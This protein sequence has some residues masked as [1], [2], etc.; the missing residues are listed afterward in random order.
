MPMFERPLQMPRRR[1]LQKAGMA[2][3]P[4]KHTCTPVTVEY[5]YEKWNDYRLRVPIGKRPAKVEFELV[6]QDIDRFCHY[7]TFWK[8]KNSLVI[9]EDQDESWGFALGAAV[10]KIGQR[11]FIGDRIRIS[12][13]VPSLR[14]EATV[15]DYI[16]TRGREQSLRVFCVF[17]NE[18]KPFLTTEQYERDRRC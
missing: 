5:D 9:H 8:Q 12:D 2:V 13:Y 16:L 11:V 17:L 14:G 15:D 4:I 7:E 18:E 6:Y 10:V 1:W 3:N